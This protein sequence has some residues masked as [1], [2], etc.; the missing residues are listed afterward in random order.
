MCSLLFFSFCPERLV[1]LARLSSPAFQR[2]LGMIC[3]S[4]DWSH[5][6]GLLEV[7]G[8]GA[9]QVLTAGVCVCVHG[10]GRYVNG[11]NDREALN[12]G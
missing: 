10:G 9:R 2:A 12:R 3:S 1:P 6:G 11:Y 5:Y 4:L 8:D 7:S